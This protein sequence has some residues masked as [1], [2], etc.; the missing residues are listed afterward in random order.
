[1]SFNEN[2]DNHYKDIQ[3]LEYQLKLKIQQQFH[4]NI[5]RH[6]SPYNSQIL[7]SILHN[8]INTNIINNDDTME[9]SNGKLFCNQLKKL[10]N[11]LDNIQ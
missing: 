5:L 10:Y 1:M 11:E 9:S 2:L 4:L 3:I 8:Y 6:T 7:S